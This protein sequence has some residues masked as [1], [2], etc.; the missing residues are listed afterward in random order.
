MKLH[1]GCG[2]RKFDGYLNIDLKDSEFDCDIRK[3]PFDDGEA[4]E[5]IAIH[6]FEHFYLHE[7]PQ[8]LAEWFRVLQ[9][10]GKLILE[11]PCYDKVIEHVKK[12]SPD[13]LT[14]WAMFGDPSTHTDGEPA[15]HKWCWRISEL[16]ALMKQVGFRKVV[17]D[18]P[19]FHRPDRDM[20]LVGL[21]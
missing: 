5:I 15:L 20:R 6:V 21:K 4:E 8:V 14:R 16:A 7:A 18:N 13:N 17:L 10:A 11:L 3:L 19:K 9:D 1:L 12:G 2:K